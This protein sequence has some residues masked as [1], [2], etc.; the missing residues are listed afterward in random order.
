MSAFKNN[1]NFNLYYSDTDSIVIDQELGPKAIGDKLGQFKLEHRISRAAFLAPKVYSFVTFE[2]EQVVKIKGV[3]KAALGG[4]HFADVTPVSFIESLLEKDMFFKLEQDKWYKSLLKG[5]V[6][7]REIA[8]NLTLTASKR[9]PIFT[10]YDVD[11]APQ[12]RNEG[13]L[14]KTL[15]TA[16]EPYNYDYFDQL[17]LEKN[18]KKKQA[19]SESKPK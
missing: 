10:T 11:D 3:S 8:Y 1:P 2:G 4:I 9:K 19:E 14:T 17:L 12:L 5:I 18:S 15:F 16:T 13:L 7:V 6:S